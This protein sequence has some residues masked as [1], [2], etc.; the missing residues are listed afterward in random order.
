MCTVTFIPILLRICNHFQLLMKS[1][2]RKTALAPIE[3]EINGCKITFPKILASRAGTWIAKSDSKVIVLLNGAAEKHQIKP[4]YRK[5]PG[6]NCIGINFL[7]KQFKTLETIDLNSIESFTIILFENDK[8]HQLQWNEVEKSQIELDI[9][10]H[11]VLL[12]IFQRNQNQREEWFAKFSYGG[13][14]KIQ[15][16]KLF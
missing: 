4:F 10:S 12:P 1:V 11:L 14:I 6:F 13:K 15:K 8:L 9:I 7:R 3:Y 2:A 16:Q 5:K